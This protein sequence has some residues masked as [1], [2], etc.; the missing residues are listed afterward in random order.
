[1]KNAIRFA[2]RPFEQTK[3]RIMATIGQST[4][5]YHTMRDMVLAG[6]S[7][8]RFN[9]AH[10]GDELSLDEAE[11][12]VGHIRRLKNQRRQLLGIYFDLGGPKMRIQALLSVDA[13]QPLACRYPESRDHNGSLIE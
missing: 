11:K 10:L 12:I 13:R 3:A 7:L 8:F 9:G 1:M 2:L 6:A 4:L 5:D